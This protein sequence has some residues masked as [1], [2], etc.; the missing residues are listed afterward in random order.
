LKVHRQNFND[1]IQATLVQAQVALRRSYDALAL[2]VPDTFAGRK[3]QEPFPRDDD[4]PRGPPNEPQPP[5]P[6]SAQ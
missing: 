2:P 4:S 3:T 5:S 1:F 6:R